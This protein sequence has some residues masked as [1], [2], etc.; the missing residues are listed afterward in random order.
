MTEAEQAVRAPRPLA[1]LPDVYA[2]LEEVR[3]R[4][5]MWVRSGSL[6][7]LDSMLLG[8]QVALA[9]HGV[10]EPC[11]FWSPEGTT[12]FADWLWTRPGMPDESSLT[13]SAEIERAAERAGRPALEMFFDLLDEFRAEAARGVSP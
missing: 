5:G 11:A 13:W 2:F 4:P 10:E 9:V 7:H 12:P 1:E 3:L 8:Y 6:G